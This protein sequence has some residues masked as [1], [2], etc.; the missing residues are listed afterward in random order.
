MSVIPRFEGVVQF[1]NRCCKRSR[2]SRIF[3]KIWILIGGK[4]VSL[5]QES[6]ISV[7]F[8]TL[9]FG[10]ASNMQNVSHWAH[11]PLGTPANYPYFSL[12]NPPPS[13]PKKNCGFLFQNTQVLANL[14]MWAFTGES[15]DHTMSL[16]CIS[17]VNNSIMAM[18]TL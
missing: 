13:P 12:S 10:V 14:L 5:N 1:Q 9:I 3:T 11:Q 8:R 4:I 2:R 15:H 6:G 16:P 18:Y 7:A 17:T